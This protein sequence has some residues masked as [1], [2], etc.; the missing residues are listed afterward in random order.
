MLELDTRST[1]GALECANNYVT[2]S[3]RLFSFILQQLL[4]YV[5]YTLQSAESPPGAYLILLVSV[6]SGY[7]IR[8]EMPREVCLHLI[9]LHLI[10][11]PR[12]GILPPP[13]YRQFMRPLGERLI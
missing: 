6:C 10:A 13:Y 12:T 5:S 9:Y 2:M 3:I 7:G 1:V 11:T 8:P 4:K